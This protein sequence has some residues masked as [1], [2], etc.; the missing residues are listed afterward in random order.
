MNSILK[1]C[2]QILSDYYGDNFQELILYGS[3]ARGEADNFSDI[4]LLV[5]LKKPFNYF[6][7]LRRIVELLYPVQ[8]ESENLISAKPAAKEEFESGEILLYRFAK[9]EGLAA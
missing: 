4:D 8:L 5:L 7:E 3:M 1:K 6:Q 9:R 2:N